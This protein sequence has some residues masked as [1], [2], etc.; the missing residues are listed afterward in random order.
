MTTDTTD[1][2]EAFKRWEGGTWKKKKKVRPRARL[3]TPSPV[4]PRAEPPAQP[5]SPEPRPEFSSVLA[6]PEP[7]APEF[8]EPIEP[9]GLTATEYT[10]QMLRHKAM[11]EER[12]QLRLLAEESPEDRQIRE[13]E[14]EL[15]ALPS[16][17]APVDTREP[18]STALQSDP[19]AISQEKFEF[20]PRH[21]LTLHPE[22]DRILV[23]IHGRPIPIPGPTPAEYLAGTYGLEM[24]EFPDDLK[25]QIDRYQANIPQFVDVL[26]YPPGLFEQLRESAS[27]LVTT[28]VV[29]LATPGIGTDFERRRDAL[30]AEGVGFFDSVFESYQQADIPPWLRFAIE[31]IFDPLILAPGIGIGGTLMRLGMKAPNA[32]RV[33]SLIGKE[34]GTGVGRGAGRGVSRAVGRVIPEDVPAQ[35]VIDATDAAIPPVDT[36]LARAQQAARLADAEAMARGPRAKVAILEERLRVA[37][38]DIKN[39]EKLIPEARKR[40]EMSPAGTPQD[41]VIRNEIEWFLETVDEQLAAARLA[42]RNARRSLLDAETRL[43]R[44]RIAKEALTARDVEIGRGRLPAGQAREL[45]E[46]APTTPAAPGGVAALGDVAQA[47]DDVVPRRPVTERAAAPET[48]RPDRPRTISSMVREARGLRA[49]TPEQRAAIM[50]MA[51]PIDEGDLI[52]KVDSFSAPAERALGSDTPISR[53]ARSIPGLKQAY[54]AWTPAQMERLNPVAMIGIRK[55]IFESIETGRARFAALMWQNEAAQALGFTY[56]RGAWRAK[57]VT[58]SAIGNRAHRDFGIID[59]ILEHPENYVLTSQQQRVIKIG[60]DMTTQLLRDAQRAGVDV[61]E[62]GTAY[63]H[64][65]VIK[66]P[67]EKV[68]GSFISKRLSSRKGYTLKRAF[69]KVDLGTEIGYKYETHPLRR[70]IARMEAGIHTIS[71]AEARRQ[72]N[73]LPGV[74]KPLERLQAQFPDTVAGVKAARAARNEAKA[75]YLR[76]ENPETLMALRQAE[77]EF[78]TAQGEFFKKNLDAATPGYY[79]KSLLSGRVVPEELRDEI[80]RYIVLPE[81]GNG[82]AVMGHIRAGAQISRTMLTT[83]DL[84][85]G[86]IQGQTLFYRN[87][88]AWWKAQAH[89]IVSLIDDPT[90]YVA[91]N[92]D[93]IDEGV[94]MAAISEPTEFLFARH[95]LGS[96]PTRIPIIGPG[97]RAFNRA[98][99][100]FILVGQTELYKAARGGVVARSGRKALRGGVPVEE[101]LTQDLVSLGSAIRKSVGTESYAI[102]G[103]RPTQQTIE[104]IAFFAARFFR[105]NIGILVQSLTA[106]EG[107]RFARRQIGALLAGGTSI[108]IGAHWAI[109]GKPPNLTNPFEPNWLQVPIGNTYFNAFG[110]FYPYLRT[111]ARMSHHMVNGKPL[112]A[113]KEWRRFVISKAGLP[114]RA[115]DMFGQF[116]QNG[117]YITFEGDELGKS[118]LDIYRAIT[119]EFFTPISAEDIYRGIR[120][121]RPEEVLSLIGITGRGSAYAQMDIMFRRMEDINP[122]GVSWR[123]ADPK[124]QDE[125]KKLF[126]KI[127]ASMLKAG[128][129]KYGEAQRRWAEVNA[130]RYYAEEELIN[131]L[132]KPGVVW[133][134]RKFRSDYDSIQEAAANLKRGINSG[135]KLF[136]EERELPDDPND[137]ALA[138][139]YQA[140]ELARMGPELNSELD[141]DK[142]NEIMDELDDEW[143]PSQKAYVDENTGRTDHPPFAQAMGDARKY[144]RPFFDI[145]DEMLEDPRLTQKGREVW[146]KYL[147]QGEAGKEAMRIGEHEGL[148]DKLFDFLADRQ[149]ELRIKDERLSILLFMWYGPRYDK[150]DGQRDANRLYD[151]LYPVGQSRNV[152]IQSLQ[153]T[154]GVAQ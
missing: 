16:R 110:P 28:M 103:V 70:L 2:Q 11:M 1:I 54:G 31:M 32:L 115:V 64:R 27:A 148:L 41:E 60:Q 135:L 40:L 120:E 94:R 23:D 50:D 154:I 109:T 79:E 6:Q 147:Q 55:A 39:I 56:K 51:Y 71:N 90:A 133:D 112:Q 34:V 151:A 22:D 15:A 85:A 19:P 104:A 105:A 98:F 132:T 75:A 125:M 117:T 123:E 131:D 99:E 17:P 37:Q 49:Q 80:E 52:F 21:E 81:Y 87:N 48:V 107:G 126:P 47:V 144:L 58:A 9:P 8:T 86:F 122:E 108:T 68:S 142:L 53:W 72:I 63:W 137:R 93:F 25:R 140:F 92:F 67:K 130:K 145:N 73:R 30:R 10:E 97:L 20:I 69:D 3:P 33:A 29:E 38:E 76:N 7:I 82:S 13:Y 150:L 141:H 46:E 26:E 129:G 106:G 35:A 96:I 42:E 77:E 149:N 12:G 43:T 84:A 91:K 128:R 114:W 118:P 88:V 18:G 111:V 100:W 44:G 36:T 89:A 113:E 66:G 74:S 116:R 24:P 45:F 95:G 143:T 127:W 139:Y 121:G 59:D 124:Q 101:Q 57:K 102:L 146:G 138:Q 61:V 134:P 136:Q 152:D 14:E 119:G 83:L 5:P 62:L 153:E 78:V 4:Q 65:I